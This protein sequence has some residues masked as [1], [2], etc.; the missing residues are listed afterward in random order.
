MPEGR[1]RAYIKILQHRRQLV[2]ELI[3]AALG[4][5]AGLQIPEG[6]LL[7]ALGE[8]L[9]ESKFLAK[10]G[11]GVLIFG[12]AAIEQPNL[13]RRFIKQES[14]ILVELMSKWKGWVKAAVF[15]EWIANPDRHGGN[16]LLENFERVW[17][18]DHSHAL[19]GPFWEEAELIPGAKVDNQLADVGF[20]SL[21][22]PERIAVSNE[23]NEL[24]KIFK[25]IDTDTVMQSCYL[26]LLLT[27][28]EYN[29]VK[30]FLS[31]RV[32][33][34][35]KLICNRLGMPLLEV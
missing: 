26:D 27:S 22:L 29:A 15:D 8:D 28:S 4:R 13:R 18:I 25:T 6:F 19:T 7:N 12:S 20:K 34:L 35:P 5:A 24:V 23:T 16:L 9:P 3:S 30:N 21:T 17:L 2:S 14:D 32:A 31:E 1:V 10:S 11:E 33:L